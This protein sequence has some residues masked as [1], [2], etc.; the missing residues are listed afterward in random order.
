MNFDKYKNKFVKFTRSR[1]YFCDNNGFLWFKEINDIV[2]VTDVKIVKTIG[3]R[4]ICNVYFIDED[5][6][7]DLFQIWEENIS[8]IEIIETE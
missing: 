7:E 1:H 3:Y 4:N 5:L 6:R 2:F 8:I